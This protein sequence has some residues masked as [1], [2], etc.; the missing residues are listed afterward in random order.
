MSLFVSVLQ[1]SWPSLNFSV[2]IMILHIL[3]FLP[4][5]DSY[6]CPYRFN[7]SLF[8]FQLRVEVLAHLL[9]LQVSPKAAFSLLT[10]PV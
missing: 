1:I 6:N 10:F 9:Y 4:V 5:W 3:F 8:E 7:L 2:V